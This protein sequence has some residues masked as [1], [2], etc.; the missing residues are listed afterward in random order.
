MKRL[1]LF[2]G[3]MVLA[4]VVAWTAEATLLF[5]A[6]LR[7]GD[8]GGGAAVDTMDPE[9]GGSPH[10]LG[11]VDSVEGVTPGQLR[12]NRNEPRLL[13]TASQKPPWNPRVYASK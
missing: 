13:P 12:V 6:S 8:Y 1:V 3:G 4:L 5:E 7:N 2:L 11:I 9:H 10:V